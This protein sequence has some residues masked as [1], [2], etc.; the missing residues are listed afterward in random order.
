MIKDVLSFARSFPLVFSAPFSPLALFRY[1][2]FPLPVF[3]SMFFYLVFKPLVFSTL[4]LFPTRYFPRGFFSPLGFFRC[5]FSLRRSKPRYFSPR[6]YFPVSVSVVFSS[7]NLVRQL[8]LYLGLWKNTA[9]H[10]C[11]FKLLSN[12]LFVQISR[13]FFFLS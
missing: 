9:S 4:F 7:S 11:S 5:V 2:F 12:P 1:F 10:I 6:S 13:L 3:S 8:V